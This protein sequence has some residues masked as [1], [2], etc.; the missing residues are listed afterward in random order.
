MSRRT[1]RTPAYV[2]AKNDFKKR[3][4]TFNEDVVSKGKQSTDGRLAKLMLWKANKLI[5]EE[6]W[7]R[8]NTLLNLVVGEKNK[9]R[10]AKLQERI[11]DLGERIENLDNSI[12]ALSKRLSGQK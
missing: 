3:A 6:R 11:G 4:A 1:T 8:A 7:K 9:V 10:R 5:L 12:V 2:A